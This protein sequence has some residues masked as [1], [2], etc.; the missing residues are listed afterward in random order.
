M[1]VSQVGNTLTFDLGDLANAPG[2]AASIGI[3]VKPALPGNFSNNATVTHNGDDPNP[4]DNSTS[5]AF[6]VLPASP[7]N[8][9]LVVSQTVSSNVV[10]TGDQFTYTVAVTNLGPDAANQ[11]VLIDALPVGV[12]FVSASPSQGGSS[13]VESGVVAQFGSLAA[14]AGAQ[15][16]ITVQAASP[17]VVANFATVS[18]EAGDLNGANN[19][20]SLQTLVLVRSGGPDEVVPYQSPG[21]LYQIHGTSDPLPAGFEQFDFDAS[22]W[23]TGA[24]AFG[25]RGSCP[26]Q[27]TVQTTWPSSTRLLVRREFTL[28]CPVGGL[29]IFFT[30]DNDVEAVFFN[31]VRV[32]SYQAHEGCPAQDDFRI[33]VPLALVRPGAGNRFYRAILLPQ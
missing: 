6:T 11:V 28:T 18:A 22:A 30:V 5:A 32:Q 21:W 24:A 8:A 10:R 25:N 4:A 3:T 20:S 16:T 23:A 29:H 7:F 2:A 14:G 15:V 26:L 19:S 31:E 9:D 27:A 13:Q 17:G 12:T 33:D 1:P